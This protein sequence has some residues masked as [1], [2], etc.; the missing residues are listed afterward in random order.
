MRAFCCLCSNVVATVQEPTH[1]LVSKLRSTCGSAG[2]HASLSGKCPSAQ[3]LLLLQ[4]QSDRVGAF[5]GAMHEWR[6]HTSYM[7]ISM[8]HGRCVRAN[9][10]IHRRARLGFD[11]APGR[12]GGCACGSERARAQGCHTPAHGRRGRTCAGSAGSPSRRGSL[13]ACVGPR[14]LCSPEQVCG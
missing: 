9:A 1:A 12:E 7:N 11:P 14:R 2:E 3:A 6:H 10:H 8:E 5:D 4:L 13:C